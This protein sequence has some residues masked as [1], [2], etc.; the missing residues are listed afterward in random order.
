MP[1]KCKTCP[2]GKHG[3]QDVKASVTARIL[4]LSSSQICHHPA[5]SDKK[6]THLCRGGRDLQ[7]QVLVGIGLLDKPTDAAFR[8]KSM[9]VGVTA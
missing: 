4:T 8:R 1:A 6:Q 7:L 2:F 9:A 5:L 3:D